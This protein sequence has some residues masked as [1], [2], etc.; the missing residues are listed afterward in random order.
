VRRCIP[1]LCTVWVTCAMAAD[2]RQELEW[3]S[4]Y[5][6]S[7]GKRERV[8]EYWLPARGGMLLGM[9]RTD[10]RFEFMRIVL[11]PEITFIAQPQGGTAVSFARTAGGADWIRFEN[12]AHDFPKVIEYRREGEWLRAEVSAAGKVIP[13]EYQRCGPGR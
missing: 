3:I 12:P 5:W 1:I 6:C 10:T 7:A 9:S 13:F 11:Q 4:G 8:E 2:T